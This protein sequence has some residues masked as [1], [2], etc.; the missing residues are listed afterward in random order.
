M[1]PQIRICSPHS[2]FKAAVLKQNTSVGQQGRSSNNKARS[3]LWP[4]F[5]M[6]PEN[7]NYELLWRQPCPTAS[8]CSWKDIPCV[9]PMIQ[10]E[11]QADVSLCH[12]GNSSSKTV[13]VGACLV[14]INESV[15]L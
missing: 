15:N 5:W 12:R 9:E 1:P 2:S 3:W 8:P 6:Q 14:I 10:T 13:F 7:N 11:A 4:A